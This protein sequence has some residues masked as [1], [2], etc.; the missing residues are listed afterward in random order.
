MYAVLGE[1]LGRK[2]PPYVKNLGSKVKEIYRNVL[3]EKIRGYNCTR[4]HSLTDWP[5]VKSCLILFSSADTTYQ[6]METQ[7]VATNVFRAPVL[8]KYRLT[9]Q[10]FP[11]DLKIRR[12]MTTTA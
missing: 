11:R 2:F 8:A 1:V 3:V 12:N 10:M 6:V 7:V 4:D 5:R 9:Y